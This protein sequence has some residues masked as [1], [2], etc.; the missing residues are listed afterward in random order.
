MAVAGEPHNQAVAVVGDVST[1]L[2]PG[3]RAASKRCPLTTFYSSRCPIGTPKIPGRS[4]D[5]GASDWVSR[6]KA[7]RQLKDGRCR[8][9]SARP[10]VSVFLEPTLGV[11]GGFF[12]GRQLLD[13][14]PWVWNDPHGCIANNETLMGPGDARGGGLW[15]K[16]CLNS[17]LRHIRISCHDS[18]N[19][20][21]V[22]SIHARSLRHSPEA[23]RQADQLGTIERQRCYLRAHSSRPSPEIRDTR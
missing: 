13:A 4:R 1:P 10:L 18:W 21:L 3:N 23:C 17:H 12:L 7:A 14:V 9:F 8:C 22:I 11:E 19:V 15:R 16:I 20:S 5:V 6:G 2:G